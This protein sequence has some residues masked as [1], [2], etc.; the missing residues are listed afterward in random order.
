MREN[1]IERYLNL[2]VKSMCGLSIKMNSASMKGLP[3][4]MILIPRGK[5][6]FVELKAP[7]KKPR[8]LQKAVHSMLNSMGFKILVIDTKEKVG[9]FI[10]GIQTSQISGN[11]YK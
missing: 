3:D 11:S 2:K 7:G 6:Y 5:I 10:N 9:E 1:E 8:P 4:R